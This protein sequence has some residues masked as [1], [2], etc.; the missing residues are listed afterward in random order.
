MIRRSMLMLGVVC[1]LPGCGVTATMRGLLGLDP[2]PVEPDWKSV[3]LRTDDDANGNSAV[4]VDVVLVK[5]T[6]ML[7]SLLNMTASKWFATRSDLRKSFPEAMTVFSYEL[8]PSQSIKLSNKLWDGQKAWA[9]LVFASYGTPGDHRARM[10]LNTAGY[11]VQLRAQNFS[12]SEIKSGSA[13]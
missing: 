2:K 13:Q 7:E 8:A 11:V 3:A 1:V 9:A 5:E 4:A 6:A 12:A 10:L